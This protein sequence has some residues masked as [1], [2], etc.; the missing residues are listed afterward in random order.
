MYS[1]INKS[2]KEGGRR[3]ILYCIEAKSVVEFVN[4]ISI[5]SVIVLQHS[6]GGAFNL[7]SRRVFFR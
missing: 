5:V 1:I 4:N 7:V 3:E 6:F 2:R